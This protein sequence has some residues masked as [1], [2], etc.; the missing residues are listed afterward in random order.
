MA[1]QNSQL[2]ELP[3]NFHKIAS[4][5]KYL[6]LHQN[7]ISY[8]PQDFYGFDSLEILDLASNDLEFLPDSLSS[9][10]T[11]KVISIKDNSFKYISPQLGELPNLN[12]IEVS[13]NPSL[14]PSNDIIRAFQQQKPDLDWVGELKNYLVA[15]RM[16]INL[17]IQEA[18][19]KSSQNDNKHQKIRHQKRLKPRV[20][21]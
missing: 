20:I 18:M 12:L 21:Q 7:S 6:D 9:V 8:I 16:L 19:E 3:S 15:N 4:S 2:I 10:T 13:G 1:I 5:I 11:L 17:K 14:L